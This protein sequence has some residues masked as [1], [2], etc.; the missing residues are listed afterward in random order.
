[1]ARRC[2]YRA[3]P[4]ALGLNVMLIGVGRRLPGTYRSALICF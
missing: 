2:W 3:F 1:M 4:I